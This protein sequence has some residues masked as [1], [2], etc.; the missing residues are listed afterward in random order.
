M[1]CYTNPS[2]FGEREHCEA[3]N[4][5]LLNTTVTVTGSDGVTYTK[6]THTVSATKAGTITAKVTAKP[7]LV[8]VGNITIE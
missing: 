5:V 2:S 1:E 7:E 4:L 6:A 8:G 3:I